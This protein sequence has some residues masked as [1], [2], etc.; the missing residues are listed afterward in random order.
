MGRNG[1]IKT[2]KCFDG[3][4]VGAIEYVQTT[5]LEQKRQGKAILLISENLDETMHLSDRIAVIYEGEIARILETQ[6]TDRREVG[7][8]YNDGV[9]RSRARISLV[10]IRGSHTDAERYMHLTVAE[11][12]RHNGTAGSGVVLDGGVTA[13]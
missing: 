11:N 2:G 8:C 5:L 6:Y 9:F 12:Q 3:L 1:K 4:D 10:R 7:L 13:A